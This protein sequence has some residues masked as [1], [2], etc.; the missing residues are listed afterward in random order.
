MKNVKDDDFKLLRGFE[1]RQT[2]KRTDICECRVAFA[3]ENLPKKLENCK[4]TDDK[5]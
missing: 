2:D 1:D 4:M 3:T 5:G